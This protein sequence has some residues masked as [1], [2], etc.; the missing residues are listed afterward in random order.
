MKRHT[1]LLATA[2]L[3]APLSFANAADVDIS[4][5]DWS[6]PYLGIQGGFAFGDA[7]HSFSNG[8]PSDNSDP[9]GFLG[10]VHAGFNGQ[11][12]DI[13]VG[14]EVD[15]ELTG[16]N[17]SFNNTTGG[18]SS[19]ST[20]INSQGSLRARIG[21]PMDRLLPYITGG[22]AAA[23][24]DY[25][26]GPSGGPCCGF[27]KTALGYTLG[28]GIEYAITDSITTRVEYRYTDFGSES[29]GLSPTFPTVSMPT[30]LETHAVRFGLSFQF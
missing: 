9:E 14:L 30:D 8:A 16:I 4:S 1:L 23:D 21:L 24:V 3:L 29:G 25:G 18:T 17:G 27:S 7:S 15:A 12:G 26:G 22:L 5:Y 20:D 19:G 13:L 2:A 11:L 10:G 6:G 28:A